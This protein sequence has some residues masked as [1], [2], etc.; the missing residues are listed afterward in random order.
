[1]KLKTRFHQVPKLRTSGAIPLVPHIPSWSAQ[2]RYILRN[3]SLGSHCKDFHEI[4]LFFENLWRIFKSIKSNKTNGYL[5]WRCTIMI[6]SRSIISRMRNVSDKSGKEN[7]NIHRP[8]YS[9]TFFRKS[10]RLW[11]N[12]E[13]SS[14]IRQATM[15]I[16]HMC[17]ASHITKA[18]NTGSEYVILIALAATMVT[19]MRFNVTL[20]VYYRS[21]FY[22]KGGGG[23]CPACTFLLGQSTWR[24]IHVLKKLHMSKHKTSVRTSQRTWSISLIKTNYPILYRENYLV[25]IIRVIKNI[26]LLLEFKMS[27][28]MPISVATGFKK[29]SVLTNIKHFHYIL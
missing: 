21:Y 16:W 3:K 2:W 14:R 9:I 1:V 15:T 6:I 19:W 23:I 11:D 26:W 20:N 29:C 5:T 8:I 12:V 22:L 7:Q 4:W 27:H 10:C 25:L 24:W 18:T 13:K 17:F 28:K